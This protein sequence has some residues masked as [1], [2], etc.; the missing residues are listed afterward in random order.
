MAW[1]GPA[2]SRAFIQDQQMASTPSH[3]IAARELAQALPPREQLELF[4]N[5]G[6]GAPGAGSP[7]ASVQHMAKKS[8][9]EEAKSSK[10]AGPKGKGGKGGDSRAASPTTS[11]ICFICW[12]VMI[13]GL[14]CLLA[15]EWVPLLFPH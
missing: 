11:V 6:Q 12:A 5:S 3:H 7:L 15:L 13:G 10:P 14:A 9:P 8:K 4:S 2:I 1:E